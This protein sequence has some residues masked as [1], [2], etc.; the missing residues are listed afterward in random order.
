MAKVG[1]TVQKVGTL[2][3]PGGRTIEIRA[4]YDQWVQW[5]V[6]ALYAAAKGQGGLPPIQGTP[7]A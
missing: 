3:Y 2:C 4:E 7:G 1:G 6:D 5:A